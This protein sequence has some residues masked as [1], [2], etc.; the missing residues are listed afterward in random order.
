MNG[1]IRKIVI[2]CGAAIAVAGGGA[3]IANQQTTPQSSYTKP[4][5]SI[6]T[7]S[8]EQKELK[9]DS[10]STITEKQPIVETKTETTTRDI[11]FETQYVDDNS[12]EQG[13]TRITQNG[14]KGIETT[15]YSVTYTDDVET[16]REVIKTEVTRQPVIQIVARG[17]YVAPQVPATPNCANGTYVNS[18]GNTVCRPVQ[19][20]TRPAGATARCR[21]G[22]YS[23]S[24]SRRG[25]CSHHGGVAQWY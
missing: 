2:S 21:D 8:T 16:A 19:S 17:T 1:V 20:D 22:S 4:T 18:A 5:T 6:E 25:T 12:L 15:F 11:P 14:I 13:A 24:Q 23:Y 3:A 10:Q 9:S 7:H